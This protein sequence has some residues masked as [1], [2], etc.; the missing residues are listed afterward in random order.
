MKRFLDEGAAGIVAFDMVEERLD[1]LQA[2][3]GDRGCDGVWRCPKPRGQSEGC[4]ELAV[5]RF[6]RLDVFVGN[7]GVRD[8]RKRL[9]GMGEK[10]LTQGFDDVFGVN[11]KGSMIGSGRGA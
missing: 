1:A 11:V 2:A 9:E 3:H 8:G 6:G 10:E 4:R 5:S 7:A